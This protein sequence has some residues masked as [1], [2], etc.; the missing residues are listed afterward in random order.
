MT[1]LTDAIGTYQRVTY[2]SDGNVA[3]TTNGAGESASY[4]Y[5]KNG[6]VTSVT[7]TREE[8]GKTITFTSHYSYNAAG[9]IAESIDNA[10]N[11]TKY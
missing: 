5:D 9:D 4:T 2:D 10:G 3:S 1:G 8:D 6:K 7:V 11:V